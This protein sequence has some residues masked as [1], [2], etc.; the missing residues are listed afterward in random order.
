MLHTFYPVFGGY[1]N[2]YF[3]IR[4]FE[5]LLSAYVIKKGGSLIAVGKSIRTFPEHEWF[6]RDSRLNEYSE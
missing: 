1:G 5:T 3:A 4:Y 6:S 2:K